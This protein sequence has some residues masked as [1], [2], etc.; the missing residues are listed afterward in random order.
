MY[1]AIIAAAL[2]ADGVIHRHEFVAGTV[3]NALMAIQLETGGAHH[4]DC[5]D[6]AEFS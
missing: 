6:T 4:F 5:T 2:V 3:I 1:G